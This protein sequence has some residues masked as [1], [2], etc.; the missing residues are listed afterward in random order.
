LVRTTNKWRLMHGRSPVVWD[1]S[2]RHVK[3]WAWMMYYIVLIF[4]NKSIIW[5]SML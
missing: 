5:R 2:G 4:V 3:E 1:S